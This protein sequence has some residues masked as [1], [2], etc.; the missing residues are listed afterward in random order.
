MNE[1]DADGCGTPL[2]PVDTVAVQVIFT[3][4][5]VPYFAAAL[6]RSA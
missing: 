2:S 1:Q 3:W 6:S 4:P 5:L